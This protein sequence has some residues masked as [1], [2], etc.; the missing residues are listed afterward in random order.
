MMPGVLRWALRGRRDPATSGNSVSK[1]EE[2]KP[3]RERAAQLLQLAT[4]R[5]LQQ[6][7]GM[8]WRIQ[9]GHMGNDHPPDRG[10]VCI[11]VE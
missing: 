10:E 6:A 5:R 7:P 2:I 8:S 9:I 1:A 11:V 4:R 3:Q